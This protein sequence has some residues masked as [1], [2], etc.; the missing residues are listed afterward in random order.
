MLK[1]TAVLLVLGIALGAWIWFNPQ[2]HKKA[3]QS[4]EDTKTAFVS[5]KTDVS[6]K[7]HGWMIDLKSSGQSGARQVDNVWKEISSVFTTLWDSIQHLWRSLTARL[8]TNS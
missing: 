7:T 4:W 3:V 1:V 8:R 5:M 2:T 6:A